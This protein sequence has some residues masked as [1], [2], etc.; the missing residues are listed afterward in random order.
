MEILVFG[1]YGHNNC[2]DESY[3]L[4]FPIMFPSHNFKFS[5]KIDK[6]EVANCDLIVL[7]GGN[8]LKPNF[9][10]ELKKIPPDKP[11]YAISVGGEQSYPDAYDRFKHFYV[12]D[13]VTYNML[14]G[15]PRTLMPDLAFCLQGDPYRGSELIKKHFEDNRLDLYE[16]IVVV[17]ISAYLTSG[18]LDK[19]ARE[20]FHFLKFSYD[21]AQIV[22]DTPASFIFLP[23]GTRPPN[24]DRVSNGWIAS[25]CK[26]WKKNYHVW[27]ELTVQ[28]SLDIIAASNLVI[29]TR[30]HCSLFAFNCGTPLID[31]THHDKNKN[32]LNLINKQ[33]DSI[34]YWTLCKDDLQERV[35]RGLERPKHNE[36]DQFREMLNEVVSEIS[37]GE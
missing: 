24:D 13:K 29:S 32:F 8:I 12:R 3:K 15:H 23:F 1:W 7:G 36:A 4:S 21:L 2:G 18:G 19:L 28:D 37:F 22:D 5:N 31:I 16:K 14:E 35:I 10:R 17:N 25:K 9:F 11:I 6:D 34:F 26:W 33:K 27:G 20:A 30:L